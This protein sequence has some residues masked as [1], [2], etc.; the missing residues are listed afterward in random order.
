M[1]IE[2]AVLCFSALPQGNEI[3]VLGGGVRSYR[4][5]VGDPYCHLHLAGVLLH[6]DGDTATPP[7][8]TSVEFPNGETMT[9]IDRSP[10]TLAATSAEPF[11]RRY[12]ISTPVH[13][14][15]ADPGVYTISIS[16]GAATAAL[17][18]LVS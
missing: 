16:I 5:V 7:V 1:K 8:S 10:W 18:V 15:A 4:K 11:P 3:S 13:F 2:A 14:P 6:E 17:P 9:L 12:P